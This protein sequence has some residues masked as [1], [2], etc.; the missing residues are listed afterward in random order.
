MINNPVLEALL[1]GSLIAFSQRE[2]FIRP[3][4][5]WVELGKK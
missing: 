4:V 2:I 5:H 3:L 1:N